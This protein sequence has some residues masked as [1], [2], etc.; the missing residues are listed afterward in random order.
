M[1]LW[2]LK[3]ISA[4]KYWGKHAAMWSSYGVNSFKR[5][6]SLTAWCYTI[7]HFVFQPGHGEIAA[8]ISWQ[9]TLEV[10]RKGVGKERR[11][12]ERF[13]YY[14][15]L[16]LNSTWDLK[17]LR[18]FKTHNTKGLKSCE[19]LNT[20]YRVEIHSQLSRLSVRY[21]E[22]SKESIRAPGCAGLT[23]DISQLTGRD[24]A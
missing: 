11:E 3:K 1:I 2:N 17:V 20:V 19:Q 6:P 23:L 15:I 13:I 7:F 21:K 10:K 24:D 14:F 18:I 9:L 12:K 8:I 16:I 5:R 4:Y 22:P